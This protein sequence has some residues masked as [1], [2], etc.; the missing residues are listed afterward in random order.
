MNR[1]F[2]SLAFLCLA[3]LST[4]PCPTVQAQSSQFRIGADISG[5][6]FDPAQS[7][8][9][10]IVEHIDL[11]GSPGLAVSWFTYREGRQVWLFGVGPVTGAS[12]AIPLSISR[13]ADFPPRFVPSEALIEP[14]GTLT[15]AFTST[16][17][18][19]ASWISSY[20]GFN[21]GSQPISRLTALALGGDNSNGRVANCHSGSW[22]DPAQSGHGIFIEVIGPDSNRQMV[23]IWYAYLNGEQRWITALGPIQ[24]NTATLSAQITSGADFPPNFRS[25]DV[26]SQ[27]WGTM[28]FTGLDADRASWSW[29]STVDGFGSGTLS[30]QRLTALNGYDCA[31][32]NKAEANRFLTQTSFGPR[33][34]EGEAL[35]TSS[36]SDWIASQKLQPITL[37]R[38]AIEQAIAAQVLTDPRNAAFYSAYRMERWFDSALH[39]PDQLRQRMA[40]ALS[41]ILV[42]SDQGTLINL[43]TLMAEYN[44]ILLRNAFG[45]YRTLL[46]EVTLSPAMGLFLS[47]LRNQKTDWTLDEQGQLTPGLIAPDENY[48]REVMQLFSIGLIERNLDFSPIEA[49]GQTVPT[50]AQ[51]SV[52]ENAKALTG[53]GFACTGPATVGTINLNRNCGF[54]SGSACQFSTTAFFSVPTR[55]ALP[56]IVT[57]LIHPDGYAP[58]VCYPRYAD[59]GRSA[60]AADG[61]AVLPAPHDRKVL[62]GEVTIAASAVACHSGTPSSEQQTCI[63]YCNA[64]IDSLIDSLFHHPNLAPFVSRQLIQRFVS[65]NPSPAYIERVA[66]V[67]E[68]NG[69][70][71]RGDLGAV[72]G[73]VLLDPEARN[74]LPDDRAGKLREPLLKI[75]ALWRAFDAQRSSQG[76]YGM[77]TP[78]RQF[79][80]RPL[81][82]PSVFNFYEPDY[83]PPGALAEAGL[84]APEFQILNE[85]SAILAADGFWNLVFSGY[86]VQ[87]NNTVR[88][89]TPRS[90]AYL[91]TST[92]DA[93]PGDH[94]GLVEELNQRLLYGRMTDSL[95]SRLI[96]LLDNMGGAEA[97][98]KALDLI[99]L[100]M[101]SPAF[102]IQQ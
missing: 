42:V 43:P 2:H 62:L 48:A 30:L 77:F 73:A 33:P 25:A 65:S 89:N 84:Y 39:A 14:W 54:C 23:A 28:T 3:L 101:I 100:V 44:D 11:G 1:Q 70:G 61:Y 64:Q 13:G 97:R 12:A 20:A 16:D 67:F 5:T 93:L 58:M 8:Q 63:D 79:T 57:A 76:A 24:G 69:S 22:F 52:S 94:A 27:P 96:E 92:L 80:Q 53:F 56:G 6:F 95:R 19:T 34:G 51:E 55:Y 78:E 21:N 40:F 81:G 41:Q 9:G 66:R 10:F 4:S 18:G 88:F 87:A 60:T 82:A 50:Y 47:H 38:P 17:A 98:L 90:L 71:V 72:I 45:N 46:K 7:G 91:P 99:H 32:R 102:A 35:T 75:T 59:T 86:E 36:L 68:N 49:G 85:S 37:Q 26:D 74:R 15:L 29:S 31:P 83:Q